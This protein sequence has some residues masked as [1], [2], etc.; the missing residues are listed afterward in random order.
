MSKEQY[1]K[2][3]EKEIHNINKKIDMKI[4]SGE[5]YSKEARDHKLLRKKLIQ[6]S[7]G[8]IVTKFFHMLP[9][10]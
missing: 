4:L 10:F 8:N 9:L 6:H 3:I 5:E 2:I 7:S 1:L